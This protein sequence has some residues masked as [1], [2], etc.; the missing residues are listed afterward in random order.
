MWDLC[1]PNECCICPVW[2]TASCSATVTQHWNAGWGPSGQ[3]WDSQWCSP[4]TVPG[5]SS[6]TTTGKTTSRCTDRDC[7]STRRKVSDF[8]KF[9]KY[10]CHYYYLIKKKKNHPLTCY[11]INRYRK[12]IEL[13]TLFSYLLRKNREVSHVSYFDKIMDEDDARSFEIIRYNII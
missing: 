10:Y 6:G 13:L 9:T 11:K 1:W 2:A 8:F 3:G 7:T 4:Y 12:N 5:R